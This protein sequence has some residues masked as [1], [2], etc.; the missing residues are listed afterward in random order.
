M[1]VSVCVYA[2]VSWHVSCCSGRCVPSLNAPLVM[3]TVCV[4]HYRFTPGHKAS[5]LVHTHIHKERKRKRKKANDGERE[6]NASPFLHS[7]HK[8]SRMT[9]SDSWLWH[10][11]HHRAGTLAPSLTPCLQHSLALQRVWSQ[12]RTLATTLNTSI[13]RLHILR[14][15]TSKLCDNA[16]VTTANWLSY[17]TIYCCS[18]VWGETVI[19]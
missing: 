9:V 3:P 2:C 19:L 6:K 5:L 10:D 8:A 18:K 16:T 12:S 1:C 17:C 11:A 7:V 4:P 14:A 15:Y 13:H